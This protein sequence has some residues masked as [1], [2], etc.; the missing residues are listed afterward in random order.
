MSDAERPPD[1]GPA[2][3]RRAGRKKGQPGRPFDRRHWPSFFERSRDPLFVLNRQRRIRFVNE[4]WVRL[5]GVSAEDAYGLSCARRSQA[6]DLGRALAPPPEVLAGQPAKARRPVPPARFGPPWWEVSFFPVVGG[7]GLVGVLGRVTVVGAAAPARSAALP[8]ALAGLRAR[9]QQRFSFVTL[10]SDD[11]VCM[12]VSEQARLAAERRDPLL[13]LGEPGT[14]KRW[15]ARVVHHQGVT[16]EQA[17]AAADAVALPLAVLGPMVFGDFGLNRP[18]RLGTLFVREPGALPRDLQWRLAD[19]LAERPPDGPRV[20]AAS[21]ADPAEE[22]RAG[23]LLDDLYFR[24]SVQTIQLPPLRQRLDDLPLTIERL[25]EKFRVAGLPSSPGLTVPAV[26]TLRAYPWPGNLRELDAVLTEAAAQAAGQTIDL[27][28]LPQY[29]RSAVGQVRAAGGA[30]AGRRLPNLDDAL[31]QVER[32]LIEL[33]LRQC[34][35]NATEAA[36]RL[37]IWRTRMSRRMNK[38]GLGGG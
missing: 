33:A 31:E 38:F 24:L 29:L 32:R 22:V 18:D 26:E 28:H 3:P 36:E 5:T 23:R 4:A 12:R 21:T 1:G 16:R 13:L 6:K 35:G 9:L 20:I 27:D 19:Y 14:G 7:D 10:D 34:K 8:E 30:P 15:L 11:A 17:F 25:L 37:G 2:A